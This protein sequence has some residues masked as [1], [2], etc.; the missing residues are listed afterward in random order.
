LNREIFF[1]RLFLCFTASCVRR[2]NKR[3]KQAAVLATAGTKKLFSLL[4]VTS[5]SSFAFHKVSVTIYNISSLKNVDPAKFPMHYCYC[6]NNMTND[7]TDFT[8]LL[9]DII[10]NSTSYLTE[11]F[12][13]TSIL[14]VR[15][16]NDSD[17]IYICV[18]TGQTGK[19]KVHS[20]SITA[21]FIFS[22]DILETSPSSHFYSFMFAG[23]NLSDFWEI[24]EKSP[25]INYTFSSNTSSDL[26]KHNLDN[27]KK[28]Q[29]Q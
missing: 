19:F 5:Y 17:C 7:L 21:L 1:L 9:V 12:K 2:E 26:G 8:A 29:L 11:I 27:R 16:S 23:R 4:S 18:M 22:D 14:S 13:S 15:Q 25:V 10:G 28:Q 24:L 6:L 3:E 20:N